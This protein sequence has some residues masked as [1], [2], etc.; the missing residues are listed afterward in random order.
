[1]KKSKKE[2][3]KICFIFAKIQ[4]KRRFCIFSLLFFVGLNMEISKDHILLFSHSL[5][6]FFLFFFQPKYCN[7]KQDWEEEMFFQY[8]RNTKYILS[9]QTAFHYFQR[10][11]MRCPIHNSIS[12][13]IFNRM[14][15]GSFISF[16]ISVTFISFLSIFD[17]IATFIALTFLTRLHNH[18]LCSYFK[19]IYLPMLKAQD[20]EESKVLK[21]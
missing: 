6:L 21:Y 4:I 9:E 11:Q 3:E 20:T 17:Y 15:S 5:S 12:K 10:I 7:V 13:F 1:M 8:A 18:S 2:D 19:N 16:A 14:C